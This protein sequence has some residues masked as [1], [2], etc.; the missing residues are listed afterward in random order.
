MG[1]MP[2]PPIEGGAR[3]RPRRKRAPKKPAVAALPAVGG[4]TLEGCAGPIKYKYVVCRG[5]NSRLLLA[6]MRERPWWGSVK[7]GDAGGCH[8]LWEM[9]RRKKRF[10]TS[11]GCL[12]T[13]HFEANTCLVT[14]KG[15]YRTMAAFCAARGLEMESFMPATYHLR[16]RDTSPPSLDDGGG[17]D[18]APA[19]G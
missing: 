2:L 13:N 11:A 5:N 12:A 7:E 9:Y 16:P 8:F 15:L 17:D 3:R 6:A 10:E 1:T 19:P 4:P 18:D 14:K